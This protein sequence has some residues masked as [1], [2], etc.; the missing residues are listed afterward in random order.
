MSVIKQ[1]VCVLVIFERETI[2]MHKGYIYSSNLCQIPGHIAL[3]SKLD[4]YDLFW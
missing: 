1:I 3:Y 2:L 4:L